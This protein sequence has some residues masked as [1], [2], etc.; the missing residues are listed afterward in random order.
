M[1]SVIANPP[2][3]SKLVFRIKYNLDESIRYYKAW[4]VAKG[5][6]HCPGVDYG[7]KNFPVT[8]HRRVRV[9]LSLDALFD[10]PLHQLDVY[11]AFL[12]GTLAKKD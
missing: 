12:Q 9:I 11:N 1:V 8:K 7:E 6:L 10:W 2:I 5:F 4:I 3:G